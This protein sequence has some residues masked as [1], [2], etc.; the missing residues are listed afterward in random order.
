MLRA[1]A[2]RP[3]GSIALAIGSHTYAGLHIYSSK[4]NCRNCLAVLIGSAGS[5]PSKVQAQQDKWDL[6]QSLCPVAV[7]HVCTLKRQR[8]LPNDRTSVCCF[9]GLPALVRADSQKH[10]AKH[11]QCRR[12]DQVSTSEA[13]TACDTVQIC[14]IAQET[15]DDCSIFRMP[16]MGCS[17]AQFIGS[18]IN[19]D[20]T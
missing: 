11:G 6:L 1:D 9:P 8:C 2:V 19:E 5:P 3:L 16:L 4:N 7:E 13:S 17:R 10:R 20:C 18:T 15:A 12:D 14:T